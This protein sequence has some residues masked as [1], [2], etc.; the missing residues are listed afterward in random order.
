MT[1]LWPRVRKA[2][3]SSR[4][5]CGCYVL[6]GQLIVRRDGRWSCLDCALKT[7]ERTQPERKIT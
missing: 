6:T 5:H 3:R 4:V 1:A 7:V 2:R